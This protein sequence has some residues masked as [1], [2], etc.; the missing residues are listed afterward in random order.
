M[1]PCHDALVPFVGT[2][3][4]KNWGKAL[5]GRQGKYL[6]HGVLSYKSDSFVHIGS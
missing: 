3:G 2:R 4:F 5:F 1:V 6:V